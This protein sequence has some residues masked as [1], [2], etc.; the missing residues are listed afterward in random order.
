ME[1]AAQRLFQSVSGG[2]SGKLFAKDALSTLPIDRLP[3]SH[4]GMLFLSKEN[5]ILPRA[6]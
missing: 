1:C 5:E 3:L 2:S 4:P 6:R